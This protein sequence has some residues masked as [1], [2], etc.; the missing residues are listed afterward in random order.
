ME[1]S[2]HHRWSTQY[3]YDMLLLGNPRAS[4]TTRCTPLPPPS[5]KWL[6]LTLLQPKHPNT[7]LNGRATRIYHQIGWNEGC[8]QF[9]A[10]FLAEPLF[11]CEEDGRGGTHRL[12]DTLISYTFFQNITYLSATHNICKLL[13][14][15]YPAETHHLN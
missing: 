5:L 1:D 11:E 4:H 8:F 12:V 15:R 7:S 9:F 13:V 6:H 14:R 2:S 10:V 3:P